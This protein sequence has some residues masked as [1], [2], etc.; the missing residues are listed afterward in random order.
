MR[1][2]PREIGTQI[3]ENDRSWPFGFVGSSKGLR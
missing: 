3:L 1:L 2:H